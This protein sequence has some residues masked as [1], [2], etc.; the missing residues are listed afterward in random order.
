MVVTDAVVVV[1]LPPPPSLP[2]FDGGD[3]SSLSLSSVV[4]GVAASVA[5]DVDET[6]VVVCGHD[7][8]PLG[9]SQCLSL[10]F[11]Q[12]TRSLLFIT[13]YKADCRPNDDQQHPSC[14]PCSH[15]PGLS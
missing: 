5:V 2:L 1:S 14:E 6:V 8:R 7:E 12:L 9:R 4:V 3:E 10:R 13:P 11:R 15:C